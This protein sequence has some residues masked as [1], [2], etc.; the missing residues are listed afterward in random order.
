MKSI[1]IQLI[2][3]ENWLNSICVHLVAPRSYNRYKETY[4]ENNKSTTTKIN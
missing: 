3:L 1:K 4:N 2:K